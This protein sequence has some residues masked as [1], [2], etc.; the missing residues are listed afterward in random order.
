[1]IVQDIDIIAGSPFGR[2]SEGKEIV[3]LLRSLNDRGNIVYG[4]NIK[5]SRAD[6][7]G[8]TMRLDESF[9]GV[10]SR[11]IPPLVHEASHKLWRKTH[12]IQKND[13]GRWKDDVDGE[14][15]AQVNEL[16]IYRYLKEEKGWPEDPLLELRLKRQAN[17]TLRQCIEQEFLKSNA[18]VPSSSPPPPPFL[19]GITTYKVKTGDSLSKIAKE[20]YQDMFLWPLIYDANHGANQ[21]ATGL[22]DPNH[23]RPDQELI[24]PPLK[25]F[26]PAQLEEARHRGRKWRPALVLPPRR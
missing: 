2:T 23:I 3:K 26:T 20:W 19:S 12:P 24:I 9:R 21:S 6:W 15:R 11:T 7:D 16:V 18:S 8:H 25:G 4:G 14:E 17:G 13:T 22:D 10:A 1:M 5:D